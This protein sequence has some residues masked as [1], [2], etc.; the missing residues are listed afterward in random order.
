MALYMGNWGYDPAHRAY[1]SIYNWLGPTW[2]I[3]FKIMLQ[4][5]Q[6][7]WSASAMSTWNLESH[8]VGI[9]KKGLPS[10]WSI[11]TKCWTWEL[12]AGLLFFLR[13]VS[14]NVW[15]KKPPFQ[16]TTRKSWQA[17][18]ESLQEK[19]WTNRRW[20]DKSGGV[21]CGRSFIWTQMKQVYSIYEKLTWNPN[22][23]S[24]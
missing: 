21:S 12:G 8:G 15:N 14:R 7:N 5:T 9:S 23:S 18:L 24:E 20:V 10:H 6:L 1:N 3:F 11:S 4:T 22:M 13:Q 2:Y 16:K 17:M 19:I